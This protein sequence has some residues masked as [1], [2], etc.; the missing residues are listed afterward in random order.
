MDIKAHH[1]KAARMLASDRYTR[2]EVAEAAGVSLMSISRWLKDLDFQEELHLHRKKNLQNNSSTYI[3]GRVDGLILQAIDS[4][5]RVLRDGESETA[6]VRAACYV[7]E[8]YHQPSTTEPARGVDEL[9]KALR[10]ISDD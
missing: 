7:L 4:L 1:K 6:I 8:R 2:K 9:R 3:Q 10:I 5:D